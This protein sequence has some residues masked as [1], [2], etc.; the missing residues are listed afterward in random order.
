MHV[1]WTKVCTLADPTAFGTAVGAIAQIFVFFGTGLGLL[2]AGRQLRNQKNTTNGQFL[3][4]LDKMFQ[5]HNK[6][7]VNL[8]PGGDWTQRTDSFTVHEW[9]EI[10]EY[11]GLF[12]SIKLLIDKGAIDIDTVE[13][14]YGYRLSNIVAN[15]LI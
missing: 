4:E 3:L 7:H 13:R 9:A 5:L 10:E 8:R 6:V 2:Y 14:M 12:E 15:P 1:D 11:M